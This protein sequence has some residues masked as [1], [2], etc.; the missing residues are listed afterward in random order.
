[1]PAVLCDVLQVAGLRRQEERGF[2][3]LSG[4]GIFGDLVEKT[5][6]E[7]EEMTEQVVTYN[8]TNAAIADRMVVKD[9]REQWLEERKKAIGGSDAPAVCGV[10]KWKTP[11]MVYQ[12]KKGLLPPQEDNESMFWG[13]TLEPVIRQKYADET[14]RVVTVKPYEVV[15]HPDLDFMAA[16]LDGIADN[17]RLLEV[18]TARYPEGWGEP[19]SN[20]IPEY[21]MIQVQHCLKVTRLSVADVAVLIGGS[22][23]RIYEVPEDPEMQGMIID[24]E[25]EFWD[26]VK[27]DTPPEPVSSEDV[28]LRW[29][30]ESK[31]V[32]VQADEQ[33]KEY[34]KRLKEVK[35]IAK[36]EDDLKAKIMAFMMEAD[37]LVDGGKKLVTWKAGKGSFR[38]DGK[39]FQ[40]DHPELHKAY[41]KQGDPSR[42]FLIK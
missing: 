41:L 37:T 26:M 12:E 33:I 7:N 20:E 35:E 9:K 36:E 4:S 2:G 38:F 21:Y 1:L 34:L 5:G 8:V 19:W 27:N 39:T 30:K 29:G 40:V 6:K 42:R 10:S 13:R 28:K 15:R 31:A 23:L 25:R 14:G 17:E 18:K 32:E 3:V 11:L 22:D 16:S 24:I